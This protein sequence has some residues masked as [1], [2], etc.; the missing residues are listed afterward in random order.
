MTREQIGMLVLKVQ[1]AFFDKP[2]L[3]LTPRQAQRLFRVDET[4]CGEVL[5]VLAGAGVL[6]KH[7]DGTYT[8]PLA[9]AA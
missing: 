8:L 1:K 5:N 4:A 9:H 7:R 3:M 2:G 6:R